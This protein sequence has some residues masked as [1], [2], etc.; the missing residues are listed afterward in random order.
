MSIEGTTPTEQIIHLS[1]Q[2]NSLDLRLLE[3]MKSIDR[4]LLTLE[5]LEKKRLAK[6]EDRVL[7]LEKKE[8]ERTGAIKFIYFAIAILGAAATIIGLKV[9]K[10]G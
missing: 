1:G 3:I 6:L 10:N 4:T 9:I 5:E 8:S 2:I 7:E